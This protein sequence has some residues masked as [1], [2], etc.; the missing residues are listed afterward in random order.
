[1]PGIEKTL[2][3]FKEGKLRSGSKHGPEVKS[4]AQAIAIGLSEQR[5]EGHKVAKKHEPHHE[6]TAPGHMGAAHDHHEEQRHMVHAPKHAEKDGA[7]RHGHD[8]E[9]HSRSEHKE[10]RHPEGSHA[11]TN[12]APGTMGYPGT[13]MGLAHDG[14]KLIGDNYS[15]TAHEPAK[16]TNVKGPAGGIGMTA[17]MGTKPHGFGHQQSQRKG[18]LRLSGHSG[19]HQLGQRKK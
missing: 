17:G 3:E 4:R 15:Q 16:L 6:A 1:M 18:N 10:P 8:M 14:G 19:S 11:S 12:D 5:K 13:I 2:H 9:Y 7:G